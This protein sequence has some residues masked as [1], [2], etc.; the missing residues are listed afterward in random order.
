[1]T[2]RLST[3]ESQDFVEQLALLTRSGI[4]L[5]DGLEAVAQEV[6]SD[7]LSDYLNSLA[8]RLRVGESLEAALA[9][10]EH[11]AGFPRYIDGLVDAGIRSGNIG[12]VLIEVVEQQQAYRDVWRRVVSALA[13]P[14]LL[15]LASLGVALIVIIGVLPAVRSTLDQLDDWTD[16]P[17]ILGGAFET[18]VWVRDQGIYVLLGF[19]VFCAVA[20]ALLAILRGRYAVSRVVAGLP[21]FGK[22]T[23]WQGFA[24]FARLLRILVSQNIPLPEALELTSVAVRNSNVA[25]IAKRL[26]HRT[27]NGMS[28]AE[29][30]DSNRNVP[31]IVVSSVRWGE[32]TGDLVGALRTVHETLEGAIGL[33]ADLLA[34]V[35]PPLAFILIACGMIVMLIAVFLPLVDAANN[36][37]FF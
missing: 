20:T 27:R 8:S 24:E 32:E 12:S 17:S 34:R 29:A 7:R 5:P 9:E 28:L 33:R 10:H 14:L 22:L 26:S 18:L 2:K 30:M 37:M 4:S 21:A 15:L 23:L 36:L 11:T 3:S 13:Y 1:M 16:L 19:V 31:G 35:L 25:E 6:D